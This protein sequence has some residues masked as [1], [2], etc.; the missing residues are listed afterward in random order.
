[1][2]REIK[3]VLKLLLVL[4]ILTLLVALGFTV[5]S[6]SA[7]RTERHSETAAEVLAQIKEHPFAGISYAQ[8]VKPE[9]EEDFL[10]I[11]E[12]SRPGEKLDEVNAVI[13][14]YVGNPGTTGAQ[15]RSYFGEIA[16]T[17]EASRSAH[18]V[19]GLDGEIIQCIPL[20]E[21]SYASN[22]RN[23]D[24][25]SIECCHPD[26]TGEFN[27]AT[28]DSLVSLCLYLCAEFDLD[29]DSVLRHYDVTGKKC[30]KYFADHP[31]SWEDFLFR[32][33]R[34]NIELK[35]KWSKYNE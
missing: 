28:Y 10:P 8:W 11:N 29:T 18:F 35:D 33:K 2:T 30:P 17:H 15:N 24:T 7:K 31:E 5:L 19:I 14:H 32:L 3:A 34:N 21:V 26:K 25:I 12:Y 13:I 6:K 20:D 27:K 4:L 1:M 22:E 23:F 16:K 9:I